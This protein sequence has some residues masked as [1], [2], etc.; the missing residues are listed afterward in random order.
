MGSSSPPDLAG[1]LPQNI[2]A[3]NIQVSHD[4]GTPSCAVGFEA[5]LTRVKSEPHTAKD[6]ACLVSLEP[7]SWQ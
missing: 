6:H 7:S 2:E 3:I 1:R 5:M 4:V